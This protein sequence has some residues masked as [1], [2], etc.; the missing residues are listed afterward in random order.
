MN[1][2]VEPIFNEKMVEKSE[3]CGSVNSAWVHCSQ[4]VTVTVHEASE[5]R[6]KKKRK[7]KEVKRKRGHRINVSKPTLNI[8]S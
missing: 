6:A 7:K 3:V 1:S 8:F 4:T 2:V 5:T